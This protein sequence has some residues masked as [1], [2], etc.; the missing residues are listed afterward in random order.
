MKERQKGGESI[1]TF[2][3]SA[4]Q[5]EEEIKFS[6]VLSSV[7]EEHGIESPQFI[8]LA[9]V[10]N[11]ASYVFPPFGGRKGKVRLFAYFSWTWTLS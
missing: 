3:A 5:S 10:M 2:T 4:E 6:E 7:A 1:R 9:Y 11:K 8:A